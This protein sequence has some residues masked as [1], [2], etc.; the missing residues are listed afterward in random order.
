MLAD[1]QLGYELDQI[2]FRV[3]KDA[4]FRDIFISNFDLACKEYGLTE[5]E[6]TSLKARDYK[7]LAELGLKPEL[8]IAL[9]EIDERE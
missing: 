2:I 4:H 7:K 8:V 6:R 9:A 5:E 3:K 1:K